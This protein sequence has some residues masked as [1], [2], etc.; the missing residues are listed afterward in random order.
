MKCSL[1][2]VDEGEGEGEKTVRLF[3]NPRVMYVQK[4][5]IE[6]II[7][8]TGVV[9]NDENEDNDQKE[10]KEHKMNKPMDSVEIDKLTSFVCDTFYIHHRCDLIPMDDLDQDLNG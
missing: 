1:F 5:P 9:L 6:L 4:K 7:I 3:V 8:A 2:K 10:V